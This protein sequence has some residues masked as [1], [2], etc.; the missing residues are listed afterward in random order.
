MGVVYRVD[1]L[2]PCRSPCESVDWNAIAARVFI[3]QISRSPCE[4]VDWNCDNDDIN[5]YSFMSLSLRERGLKL[6]IS[7][8]NNALIRRSPCE[9]VDWNVSKPIII[10]SPVSRSPCESVDWNQQAVV[11]LRWLARSL[12][13]RE[14][15]LKSTDVKNKLSVSAV[16]LLARAWIEIHKYKISSFLISCR[17]PCE[18]VDWNLVFVSL[19]SV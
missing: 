7:C 12:S 17:S 5:I 13:L 10:N 18:S 1:V 3:A 19:L 6:A 11:I 16:A 14:R 2:S 9:S 8:G 15:G 4:S